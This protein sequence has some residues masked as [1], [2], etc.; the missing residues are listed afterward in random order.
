MPQR[1][2][3]I[4]IL[5]CFSLIPM[6]VHALTPSQIFTKVKGSVVVVKALDFQGNMKAQGSGVLIAPGSVATNCHVVEDGTSYLVGR[7]GKFV[8][9]NFYG[10]DGEKDI[11]LLTANGIDVKPAQIGKATMLKVGD[12]VYAVGAPQGL[13]FSL[14]NGIVSQLRG[15]PPPLIQTTAAISPGSSGGGLFDS[16]GRLVGLTTLYI[17]GGQSLNF[18]MPVE[19]IEKVVLDSKHPRSQAEW[20]ERVIVLE[21]AENWKG[22]LTWCLEWRRFAATN[23]DVWGYLGRAYFN[24]NRY[25]EA[26][27][28]FRQALRIAP[29]NAVFWKDLGEAYLNLKRYDEAVDAYNQALRIDPQLDDAWND[30]GITYGKLSRVYD[31]VEAYQQAARFDPQNAVYWYNLGATALSINRDKVAIDAC[32]HALRINP[33][34][35]DAW[36]VLTATLLFVKQPIHSYNNVWRELRLLN[37]E[38][39]DKAFRVN[40]RRTD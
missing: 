10:G 40:Q 37:P 15:G 20:L 14:S 30:L 11:C 29:L 4:I 35:L 28:S 16:E 22:L 9:A 3:F 12:P 1:G 13:E 6:S 32:L 36:D 34:F 38:R 24:L 33:E 5:G 39:A 21:K 8:S 18:A 2:F 31:E 23:C 7:S 19:W 25:N 17:K 26:I 27:E